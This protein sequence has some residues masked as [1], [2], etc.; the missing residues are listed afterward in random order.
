MRQRIAIAAALL[1]AASVAAVGAGVGAGVPRPV[2]A[3]PQTFCSSHT[4]ATEAARAEVNGRQAQI[5]TSASTAVVRAGECITLAVEVNLRPGVHVYAPGAQGYI[6]IAWTLEESAAY[7]AHDAEMPAAHILY[8]EAID[9]KAPVYEGRFRLV[10]DV[11]IGPDSALHEG[12]LSIAG[13]LRYQACDDRMCYKPEK[14]AL[15]WTLTVE[16]K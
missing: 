4:H 13:A 14:L 3:R 8:L 16:R 1:L 11:I 6:P 12:R 7:Q 5:A 10:R 2:E 9:E 15:Q